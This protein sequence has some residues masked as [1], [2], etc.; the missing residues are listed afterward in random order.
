VSTLFT[1]EVPELF[2]VTQISEFGISH[3]SDNVVLLQ[4]VR[5]GSDIRRTLTVLKTRAS[6]HAPQVL[7]F[8]IDSTGL[9]LGD[10]IAL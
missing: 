7:E 6:D 9:T 4:Y 2:D 3:L 1:V 8:R 5:S 10:A